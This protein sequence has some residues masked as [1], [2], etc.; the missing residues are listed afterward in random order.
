MKKILIVCVGKLFA[1]SIFEEYKK[2]YDNKHN[3]SCCF[4]GYSYD[5]GEEV[6]LD[7]SKAKYYFGL[8]CD[9]GFQAGC[10]NYGLS[11]EQGY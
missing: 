5:K 1:N 8:A 3:E 10:D 6:K 4:L 2:S 7:E 11:N 9:E